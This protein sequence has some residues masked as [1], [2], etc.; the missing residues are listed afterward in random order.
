MGTIPL[1][2]AEQ[3]SSLTVFGFGMVLV[4]VG[5]IC[6]IL[7]CMLTGAIFKNIKDKEAPA[8]ST[9]AP[10]AAKPAV[11]ANKGEFAAAVSAAIA[12]DLGTD[13]SGIRI[14]SVKQL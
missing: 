13:V 14:L 8:P 12:E 9:A 5:L 10:A 1:E 11:I 4:F 7:I 2:E 6:I 3:I